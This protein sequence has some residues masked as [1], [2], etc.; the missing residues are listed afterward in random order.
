MIRGPYR[1]RAMEEIIAEAKKLARDGAKEFVLIAQDTTRYGEDL[2]GELKLPVLLKEL[3]KIDGILWIRLLYTYPDRI[4][5][6]LLQVLNDE[7][8]VLKYL[9]IPLQHAS[10]KVLKQMNRSGD[11]ES[12]TALIGKIREKVADITLR[13]TFIV[14]FPGET[15]EDFTILAEFVK[16]MRF[17]RVGC[18]AYSSEEDTP[19]AE[20]ENQLEED[21]KL[22]R[23]EIIMLEQSEIVVEK[24]EAKIGFVVEV[25]VEGFDGLNKCYYGRTKADAPDIDGKIFFVSEKTFLPGD[26]ILVEITEALE[27]DM[28]GSVTDE[29]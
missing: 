2:Y 14:G 9:D 23:Q 13:T 7:P 4:T 6:E 20:F 3:C 26:I 10:G 25:L 1:S 21:Q 29:K 16:E 19:A 15:D 24:N 8:K 28:I 11:R 12:L 22:R 17:D 18:F 27:Y 5:D